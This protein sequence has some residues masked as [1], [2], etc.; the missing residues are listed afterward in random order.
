MIPT[1]A[2]PQ[3]LA[4]VRPHALGPLTFG[5]T[6]K[7]LPVKYLGT[8]LIS[9]LVGAPL[10]ARDLGQWRSSNPSVSH[11]YKSLMQP[12]N[13]TI[14]CCGGADAYYA[15]VFET[16]GDRYVAIITD[17]RDDAPLGRH[18]V[19]PGTRIVVPNTKLKVD[20]GNP[21]GH[22]V[23]SSSAQAIPC[24]ATWRLGEF[25]REHLAKTAR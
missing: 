23:K 3:G 25:K 12:D 4:L 9:L 20:S 17:T 24:S 8:I 14:S 5:I 19:E 16:D 6:C 21:T 22:G 2:P 13:P 11:W 1:A 18:H 10:S 7:R 15:D